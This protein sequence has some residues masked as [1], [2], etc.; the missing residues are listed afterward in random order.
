MN[1]LIVVDEPLKW[2]GC[3]RERPGIGAFKRLYLQTWPSTPRT[4]WSIDVY[5]GAV[6]LDPLEVLVQ[7]LQL[8]AVVEEKILAK[9]LVYA[10]ESAILRLLLQYCPHNHM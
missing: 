5:S 6:P 3:H 9:D 4:L 2:L 8:L 1:L 10:M 7:T